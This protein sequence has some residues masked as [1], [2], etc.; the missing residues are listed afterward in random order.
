MRDSWRYLEREGM[1]GGML[2]VL[3][4]LW[5]YGQGG[6]LLTHSEGR[7]RGIVLLVAVVIVLYQWGRWDDRRGVAHEEARRAELARHTLEKNER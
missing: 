1:P 7:A 4:V 6:Y 3:A 5:C 2:Y